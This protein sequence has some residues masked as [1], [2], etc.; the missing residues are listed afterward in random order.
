LQ[1]KIADLPSVVP[2]SSAATTDAVAV[3][4]ADP[5]PDVAADPAEAPA[6]A[7]PATTEQGA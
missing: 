4:A 1:M 5:A 6:D 3:P 7:V 2:E